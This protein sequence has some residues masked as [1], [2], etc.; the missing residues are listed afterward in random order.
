[1]PERCSHAA[2]LAALRPED[3]HVGPAA[4]SHCWVSG[5][6]QQTPPMKQNP[7]SSTSHHHQ[8]SGGA[9]GTSSGT[10]GLALKDKS[11]S[12]SL[13]RKLADLS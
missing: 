7:L 9:K 6:C 8:V 3:I 12:F 4:P 2:P 1:M 10:K 11:L 13:V 5:P